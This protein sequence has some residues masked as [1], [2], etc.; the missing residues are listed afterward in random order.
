MV[1]CQLSKM[2]CSGSLRKLK[3]K[4]A[5]FTIGDD[6]VSIPIST[7]TPQDVYRSFCELQQIT[8]GTGLC[9]HKAYGLMIGAK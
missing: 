5:T 9:R 6:V 4:T 7:E 3:Q 2:G 8:F 1:S